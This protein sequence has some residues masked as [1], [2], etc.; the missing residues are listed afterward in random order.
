M[1]KTFFRKNLL[2]LI[3]VVSGAVAGFFYW[4]FVGCNSG[5]CTITSSPTNSTLYGAVMGGLLGS[6]FKKEK[7][8]DDLSR[9]NKSG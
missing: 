8:Q 6:I 7:K 4:K 3:G 5:S 2:T 9:N 1:I